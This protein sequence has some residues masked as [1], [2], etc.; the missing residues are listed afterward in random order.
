MR[1]YFGTSPV[2]PERL[3]RRRYRNLSSLFIDVMQKVE[4]FDDHFE[5]RRDAT[6]RP[7]LSPHQKT[8]TAFR[9]LAYRIAGDAV[10]EY[11]IMS[12]TAAS[13]SLK[14][15]CKAVVELWGNEQLRLPSEYD[16]QRLIKEH[17]KMGS[18]DALNQYT[19]CS[20][21]GGTVQRAGRASSREEVE[22]QA[23]P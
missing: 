8:T 3:F 10:D 16:T 15:F 1:D 6:R 18:R 20:E 11:V 4:A 14:R 22:S 7:G 21:R 2:C 17:E 23:M 9:Q 13:Q 19:A 5:Q 12:S